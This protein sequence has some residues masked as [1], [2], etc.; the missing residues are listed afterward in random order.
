[1]GGRRLG[2]SGIDVLSPAKRA[3]LN[4]YASPN[5]NGKAREQKK[6]VEPIFVTM[7]TIEAEKVDWLWLGRIPV[8]RLTLVDGDPGVGKS[9]LALKLAATVSRSDALPGGK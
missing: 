5:G 1:M 8:G 3:E 2:T 6:I 7:D 9:F 4:Q